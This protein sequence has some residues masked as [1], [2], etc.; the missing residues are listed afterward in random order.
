M[1]LNFG[2]NF[3]KIINTVRSHLKFTSCDDMLA[4]LILLRDEFEF[5]FLQVES[6]RA[7]WT[8]QQNC[9]YFS[10]PSLASIQ[11]EAFWDWSAKS[12]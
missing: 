11:C 12:A 9:C 4:L 5:C 1:G 2:P 6:R 8:T 3:N 10:K 7:Y